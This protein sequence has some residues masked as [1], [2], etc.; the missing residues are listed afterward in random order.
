MKPFRKI[1]VPVDFSAHSE[2]VVRLAAGVAQLDDGALEILHVH[3]PVAYPLP[4]GYVLYTA[5][6]L[7]ALLDGYQQR[8]H[9]MKELA[10]A[11]GATAV[12]THLRQGIAYADICQFAREGAFDLIVMG[13]HGRT[14]L[15]HL[16]LG[17]VA[18]R[19][20]RRAPCPVL[21]VRAQAVAA[22]GAVSESAAVT[23]AQ[24]CH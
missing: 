13:T 24:Q 17:S 1:L 10:H 12:E 11:S 9:G 5:Q 23:P 21:T 16:L 18:E 7:G 15:G 2:Q 20:L 14:G 8:L 22:E 19:V 3:D 4:S 6:Q